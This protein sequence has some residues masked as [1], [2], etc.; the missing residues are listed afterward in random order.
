MI[1]MQK[2]EK[3][4]I[5]HDSKVHIFSEGHTILQNRHRRFDCYYIGQIYS[6]DFARI[7]ASSVNFTVLNTWIN[8]LGF[9]FFYFV[10]CFGQ[11]CKKN[12][13]FKAHFVSTCWF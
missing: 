3:T 1:R 2:T 9:Y 13:Y 10:D 8:L 5:K 11:K 4:H 12:Q 7:V 6:E